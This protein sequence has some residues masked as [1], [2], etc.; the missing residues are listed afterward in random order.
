MDI[1]PSTI[2]TLRNRV[3]KRGFQRYLLE[4]HLK[5]VRAFQDQKIAFSFPVTA[6]IGTNGGGKST[7]L[8]AS[9]IA[10]RNVR[11]G[12]YFP[13]SNVGDTS[14][15][16]WRIEFD[17]LDRTVPATSR[18][19]TR[20]ARFAALKW[21]RD[22]ITER[23]VLVFPIQRTVPA[24]EQA[25]YRKFIGIYQAPG[26]VVEPYRMT[27]LRRPAVYLERA[28]QASRLPSL[29]AQIPTTS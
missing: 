18:P 25:R 8:G 27:W 24:G 12:D 6:V 28:L 20:S 3:A 17:I 1:P 9:A 26:A 22:E 16:N 21:R 5:N 4:L 11:P 2:E 14:M 7:I 19:R 23:N 10:Y 15:A 13:K 29:T